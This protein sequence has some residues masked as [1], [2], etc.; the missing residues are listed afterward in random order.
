MELPGLAA[1]DPAQAVGVERDLVEVD[2]ARGA[3]VLLDPG[4]FDG[5]RVDAV[6]A[7]GEVTER[8]VGGLLYLEDMADLFGRQDALFDEQ[9]TDRDTLHASLHCKGGGRP[10]LHL[11]AIGPWG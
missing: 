4:V 7:L 8:A 6:E 1:V 2:H 5:L 9:L 11:S 10:P 3:D